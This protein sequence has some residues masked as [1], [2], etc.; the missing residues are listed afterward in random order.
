MKLVFVGDVMLGRLVNEWLRLVPPDYPWGD[1]GDILLEGDI[2]F[3]NLECVL[4][5]V[6]EP[7]TKTAKIFHFRSDAKN[8]AVLKTAAIDAV[9]LAN[10]HV[11]DYGEEALAETIRILDENQVQHAGA[12][13]NRLCAEAPA[14]FEVDDKIIGLIALTDNEPEWEA[15]EEQPGVFY[16]PID[17]GS[18][19]AKRLFDL[20]AETRS[21]VDI[22]IISAHWGG[23]WGYG[24]PPEHRELAHTLIESGADLIFGHSP[25]VFRGIELYHS[26]PIFYSCGDFIDD[27]A[28]D[29]IE[30]NDESFIFVVEFGAEGAERILLYPTAIVDFQASLAWGE[31]AR[32]IAEK[33]RQLCQPL[34]THPVWHEAGYAEIN[35]ERERKTSE[36]TLR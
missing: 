26:R 2:R 13:A 4:S 6:G 3:C 28:V 27:Y 34:G 23:N 12:G 33:M 29:E 25:H 32:L 1:T 18:F 8:A 9:S 5:D 7:W 31:R 10:N 14:I 15:G 36:R 16:V 21:L 19:L 24:V 30:R 11:L 22:L 17:L 20:M 35:V